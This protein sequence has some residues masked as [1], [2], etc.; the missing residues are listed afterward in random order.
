LNQYYDIVGIESNSELIVIKLDE[1]LIKP[2]KQS[3]KFLVSKGF[4]PSKQLL[5]Y[6]I[7][8]IAVKLEVRRRKWEDKLTGQIY[9]RTFD[10]TAKGT[11][12]TKDFVAFLKAIDR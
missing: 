1:K 12:Y 8:D 5:D 6:P 3:D 2:L 7:R 10:L 4:T 9:T 11:T